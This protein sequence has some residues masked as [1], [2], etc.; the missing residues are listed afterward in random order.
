LLAILITGCKSERSTTF[1]SE[2]FKIIELNDGIYG[3]IHKIGG[4]AICN[5]G[6]ID[7]GK[8]TIIFDTFLSPAVTG[9]MVNIVNSMDLSP[10]RYVINSHCHNDHIRGNQ[11]FGEDVKII[12]TKRTKELIAEWEPQDIQ[13]EKEHAPARFNH[14][15][16]LYRSFNGNRNSREFKEILMWRPYYEVLMYSH[17]EVTTRLPDLFVD[18]IHHLNGPDRRV[19]LIAK[20][21]GHTESDLMLYLPD[22]EIA[23]TGDI[24]FNECHPYLGHGS[25]D[26]LHDWL[27]FLLTIPVRTIVPG[28]GEIGTA[29]LITGMKKYVTAVTDHANTLKEQ[30][31]SPQALE[32][33]QVPEPF[34]DW[35]FGRFYAMNLKFAYEM[36]IRSQ[37]PDTI[38]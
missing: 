8:E 25:I 11:V 9:E 23:F 31:S 6:I 34:N 19:T 1:E 24:I 12:S 27:D 4:K 15:D 13:Y 29:T 38:R 33:A 22:D 37:E 21:A 20:G 28:H 14:Y 35:W 18:S 3:C 10:I 5:A 16:S 32:E 30:G 26:G 17:K 36:A 2:N 7:N